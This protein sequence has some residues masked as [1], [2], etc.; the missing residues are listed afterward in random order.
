[1]PKPEET[2]EVQL[3]PE[4]QD[5]AVEEE[6][7]PEVEEEPPPPPPPDAQVK[8]VKKLKPR[9]KPQTPLQK[10]TEVPS[11]SNAQ[12]VHEVLPGGPRTTTGLG[13]KPDAK[14]K[15]KQ[16]KPEPPKEKPKPKKKVID[17]TKPIDR[18]ENAT[19]PKPLPS[20]EKPKHP[21]KLRDKGITGKV[22]LKLHIYRDGTVRGAKI[23]RKQT[24]ATTEDEKKEAEKLFMAAVIK[25]VKTW[26]YKP[27][28]LEGKPITV[29]HTV[30]IP[31]TLTAG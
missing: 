8:V 6:E 2:V 18:P 27:A 28:T 4:I 7:E 11:E 16:E 19:V 15:P 10:P 14:P 20:N 26:K 3:Q 1:M 12:K 31:F 23:L 29:W 13:T 30:T 24:S 25:A 22:V 9:P 21:A 5:F 17:P